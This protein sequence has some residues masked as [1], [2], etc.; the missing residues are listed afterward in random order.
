M[1]RLQ[2]DLTATLPPVADRFEHLMGLS[3]EIYREMDGRRTLRVRLGERAYFL[4]AH[5]G[6]GWRYIVKDVLQLKWPVV[7]AANEWRAIGRLAGL[8]VATPRLV[9]YGR[10]GCNPARLR[11]FVIT[12]ALSGSLSLEVLCEGWRN[13]PLDAFEI[14]L[15]RALIREVA[16]IVRRLHEGGV[17]HRDLYLCHF[18]LDCSDARWGRLPRAPRLYLIDL[19]RA[20]LRART[21]RRWLVK[22]LGALYFSAMDIGLTRHD[23]YRFMRC[24]RLRGLRQV[25]QEPRLW[26]AV[27]RRAHRLYRAQRGVSPRGAY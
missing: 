17:N 22:D 3:G 9:G 13:R 7:S 24:Y 18:L 5:T 4:K 1:I 16:R 10:R 14:Q 27:R 19:H 2:P 21:P 20:Q 25:L 8:D 23:L 11:S 15:K 12:E 26:S 6:V